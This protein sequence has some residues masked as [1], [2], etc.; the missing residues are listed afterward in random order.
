VSSIITR[1]YVGSGNGDS[2]GCFE[3]KSPES[4]RDDAL[5]LNASVAQR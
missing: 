1:L 4:L 3:S 2:C 5:G